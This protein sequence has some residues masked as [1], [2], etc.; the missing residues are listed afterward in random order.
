MEQ[1]A[2][3]NAVINLLVLLAAAISL[4]AVGAYSHSFAAQTGSIFLGLGT[5]VAL[6]GVFQMRLEDRERLEKLEFEEVAKSA[7]SAAL[8]KAEEA[9]VF[10]AQRARQQFERF[11][12]PVFTVL[13]F[14][15]ELFAAILSWRALSKAPVLPINQPLVAMGLSGLFALVLFLIGKSRQP[16][17]VLANQKQNQREKSA[18]TH[19]HKRLGF[20]I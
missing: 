4:Y 11:F 13:L 3:K 17:A 19:G 8:F 10:P 7:S 12:I 9:E 20:Y 16:R 5:L 15:L 6:V 14:L 2:Q 1:N 18:Q